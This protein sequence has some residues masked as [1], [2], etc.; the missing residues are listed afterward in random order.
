M[1]I[2][3]IIC[4]MKVAE[5][6]NYSKAA[7][8]LYISQPA[9]TRHINILEQE[10]GCRLFDRSIRRAVQLT[11]AGKIFYQGLKQCEEIYRHTMDQLRMKTENAL[12]V[13]NLMRGTTFPDPV[14][15]ATTSFMESHPSFRHFTHFIEYE[16]FTSA[17]DRGEIVICA[18]EMMPQ[19]KVYHTLKLTPSPV[20][21]H[22]VMTRKHKAFADPA[23]VKLNAVAESSLFLPKMLPKGLRESFSRTFLQLFGRLPRETIYLDSVDSVSLFL[24]SNECFTISTDWY[25]DI[26]SGEFRTI[27]LPLFTDYYAMWHPDLESNHDAIAYVKAVQKALADE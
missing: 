3:D 5:T 9:V 27:P 25:T 24:R 20:P 22:I 13:I 10:T 16:D 14:I 7:E 12:V 23:G 18:K 6:L 17:L 1:T 4:F 11:E 26:R 15:S 19:Q 2:Q 21:Y 8:A